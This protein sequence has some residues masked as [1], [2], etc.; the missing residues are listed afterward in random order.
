ML[1][2]KI[3]SMMDITLDKSTSADMQELM[4]GH[5]SDKDNALFSGVARNL[6]KGV[7]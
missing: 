7:L 5:F 2:K 1:E 6:I 4:K 3:K